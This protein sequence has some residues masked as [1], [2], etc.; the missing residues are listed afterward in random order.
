M[1]YIYTEFFGSQKQA[2]SHAAKVRKF[3]YVA[4]AKPVQRGNGSWDWAVKVYANSEY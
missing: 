3:G 4:V 1:T 2:E